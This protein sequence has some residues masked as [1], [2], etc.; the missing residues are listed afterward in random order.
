LKSHEWDC[1][2]IDEAHYLKNPKAQ[3][4]VNVVGKPANLQKH[5]E[6]VPGIRGRRILALTGTPIPNKPI[7]IWPLIH[8]LD[9]ITWK[10]KR[11]FVNQF[12]GGSQD[13]ASKLDQLQ[14]RLRS[15]VMIRRRKQDVLKDLPEK[16]R[17]LVELSAE[18]LEDLLEEENIAWEKQ[19]KEI[20]DLRLNVELSKAESQEK[21]EIA[22]ALLRDRTQAAFSEISRIRHLT[23]LAKLPGV[24][25]HM[26]AALD[27]DETHKVVMFAHHKDVVAGILDRAK[28]RQIKAVSITG[29]TKITDRQMNVDIFQNEPECRLFVGNIK[30]AG[31]GITL[32]AADHVMFSELD[33]V[34]GNVTQAEDR[35]HR[36]GQKNSVTVEHLVLDGSL[37]AKMAKTLID[38]QYVIDAALDNER[39]A[40]AASVVTPSKDKPVTENMTVD[41]LAKIAE[42]LGRSTIELLHQGLKILSGMDLDHAS[43]INEIGFSKLDVRIG[44][45]LA[46]R[47]VLTPK[48]G[49]IAAKLCNKYRRQLPE[50]IADAAKAALQ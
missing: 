48:Q 6:A 21:Y 10:S 27:G 36:I 15:T 2:I 30:A 47:F 17:L 41:K 25:D 50:N 32:T 40:L 22:V 38:K 43:S 3:R 29:E 37:D 14:D 16:R 34:P 9:P 39:P 19:E 4:T 13:G 33:W 12:C 49:A 44:H 7:E 26:M 18:G 11:W 23:A 42:K 5:E 24:M 28:E 35:C 20:D 46:D 31:V 1:V 8:F 45:S